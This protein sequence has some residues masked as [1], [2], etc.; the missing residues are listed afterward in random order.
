M[1]EPLSNRVRS[2]SVRFVARAEG[3]RGRGPEEVAS[4]YER[5]GEASIISGQYLRDVPVAKHDNMSPDAWRG[6]CSV[7]RSSVRRTKV[8]SGNLPTAIRRLEPRAGPC[9]GGPSEFP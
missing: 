1:T 4:L 5:A 3:A 2:G 6:M 8:Q 9:Y 7:S